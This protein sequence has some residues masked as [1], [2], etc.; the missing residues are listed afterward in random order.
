MADAYENYV[1]LAMS[2]LKKAKA[3]LDDG[4]MEREVVRFTPEAKR[5]WISLFNEIEKNLL[6][7]GR[8]QYA[9]DHGSKLAENIARVA[10]LLTYIELGEG[11]D[12]TLGILM[13]ATN[14]SLYFSDTYLR[15]LSVLPEGVINVLKMKDRLES[16]REDGVRY[17]RK[18]QLLQ[19]GPP[20]LRKKD[21]L[22]PVLDELLME[23]HISIF[24]TQSGMAVVDLYPSYDFDQVQWD[25]FRQKNRN[26]RIEG[27]DSV[28]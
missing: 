25:F 17:I 26:Y 28:I 10:A 22:A 16:I 9:R 5:Y 23:R 3:R 7:G 12:I 2:L 20:G 14:I 19:I 6:P 1:I 4:G 21:V 18:N 13:D 8:F 11:E 24:L 15:C 27:F